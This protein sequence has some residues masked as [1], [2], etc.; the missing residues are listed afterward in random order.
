MKKMKLILRFKNK[1]KWEIKM[2]MKIKL[3]VTLK[4][5]FK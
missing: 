2:W 1:T 4:A 5:M 3:K